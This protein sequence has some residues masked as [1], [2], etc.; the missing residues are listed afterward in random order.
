MK[1]LFPIALGFILAGQYA[2]V[3]HLIAEVVQ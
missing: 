2:L 1:P 3:F